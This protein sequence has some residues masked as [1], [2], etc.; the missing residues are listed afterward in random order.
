MTLET[1]HD[2]EC[3]CGCKFRAKIFTSLNLTENPE[4]LRL[5]YDGKFNLVQCQSCGG[6]IYANTPFIFHDPKRKAMHVVKEGGMS[7]FFAFLKSEKYFDEFM[8]E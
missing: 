3:S 2:A 5:I 1:E 4:V 8:T 6:K 7:E